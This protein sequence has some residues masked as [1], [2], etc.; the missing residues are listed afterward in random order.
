MP[1]K[2]NEVATIQVL[3]HLHDKIDRL[4]A[5]NAQLIGALRNATHELNTIRARDGAPLCI[6]WGPKGPMQSFQVSEEYF[7]K[8]VDE[9]HAAIKA[10]TEE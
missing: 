2:N 6:Q 3:S 9:C 8:L 10:A 7:N 5:I 1:K 4:M